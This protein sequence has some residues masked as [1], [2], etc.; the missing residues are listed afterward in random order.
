MEAAIGRGVAID[1]LADAGTLLE[2]ARM[3][4]WPEDEAAER[5]GGLIERVRAE[6]DD[7]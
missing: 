3:R 2:V 1:A 7:L 6:L 4:S 5:A